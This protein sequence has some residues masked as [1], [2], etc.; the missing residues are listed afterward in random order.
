M[1]LTLKITYTQE[2][3]TILKGSPGGVTGD[4]DIRQLLRHSRSVEHALRPRATWRA[5]DH[6]RLDE[7][8][9]DQ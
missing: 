9:Q 3:D 7:D 8:L 4:L 5:K 6:P 1:R 2:S